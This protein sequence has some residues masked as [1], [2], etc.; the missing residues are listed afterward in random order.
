MSH[1][2]ELIGREKSKIAVLLFHG[3]TG[4]PF[5]LKKYG[6][7]LHSQGFDVYSYSLP[8]HG[9]NI[10]DIKAVKYSD[11]L[12]CA[13]AQF[14]RL[15]AKYEQVFVSGLC[16]GAVLCLAIAEKYGKKVAGVLTLSTTL[17]L[18]GWRMPWYS[19]LLPIG[20]STIMRYYYIYPEC[21][22]YGIKNEKT[23]KVIKKLLEK[24]EVAADNFPMSCI[25]ELLKLSALVRKN[26]YKVTSPIVIIHSVEDDLASKRS[27][28]EV[29]KKVNSTQKDLI[30][31]NDSYHMLLYDNE[32]EFVYQISSQF[33]KSQINIKNDSKINILNLNLGV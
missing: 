20:L 15:T 24:S 3:L 25:Y 1:D 19:F 7:Y 11:W 31:L 9:H 32:K 17:Y 12:N 4:S 28:E 26:L 13:F 14:E 33:I 5:E 29:Y 2:F 27:A 22:P 6:L 10:R 18:D 16:L 23:R 8:G 30:L 21:E